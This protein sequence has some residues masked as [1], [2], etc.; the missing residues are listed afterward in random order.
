MTATQMKHLW[1][2]NGPKFLSEDTAHAYDV[3]GRDYVIYADGDATQPFDFTGSYGFADCE[4]WRR[5]DATLMRLAADGRRSITLLDAGC[6][7]G[8]WLLRMVLRAKELDFEAIDAYGFDISPAMI[9][10]AKAG[11]TSINDPTIQV[12]FTV[13]DITAP[14][15]FDAAKF[16][17][18]LCLYG[19]LN[20]LPVE[21]HGR[22]AAEL[23]RVT[24]DT[25][26]ATVRTA[27]SQPTIYVDRLDRAR[28]FHQDNDADWM[29][30]DLVDGRH[31]G[32]TSHLFTSDGLR[33]L[34]QEHFAGTVMVGLDVFHSRFAANKHWNPPT[35]KDQEAFESDLSE[36]EHRYA[37]SP[38]FID[39]AA[40]ILLVGERSHVRFSKTDK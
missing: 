5:L 23:S 10:L 17:V 12:N 7:P 1:S 6:G 2:L 38:H 15:P 34:F 30:V 28:A 16:D 14:L 35:L 33:L 27:G 25:L 40:H 22:V 36:L 11:A 3:A 19:V 24:R 39:R 4:I 13:N 37:C 31:L 9:T 18:S 26:F 8:T 29:E 21:M 20:H 32:F